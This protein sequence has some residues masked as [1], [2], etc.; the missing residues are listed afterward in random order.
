MH[1]TK[2]AEQREQRRREVERVAG[3]AGVNAR[4]AHLHRQAA[5]L[6]QDALF[7]SDRGNAAFAI[8]CAREAAALRAEA[9]RL[10]EVKF[11]ARGK[12]RTVTFQRDRARL[13]KTPAVLRLHVEKLMTRNGW[14]R[15]VDAFQRIHGR[16]LDDLLAIGRRK[17]DRPVGLT[18][19][20]HE[21]IS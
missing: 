16:A 8:G 19:N 6:E 9:K 10:A 17:A 20:R 5:A 13:A 2:H 12:T 4:L 3:V 18:T 21:R 7:W 11:R 14:T 15:W 1:D